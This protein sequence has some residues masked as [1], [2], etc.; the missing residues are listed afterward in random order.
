[1]KTLQKPLDH[2]TIFIRELVISKSP[3]VTMVPIAV[4]DVIPDGILAYLDEQDQ[5]Q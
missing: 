5:L 4:G 1:M 3:M 2:A